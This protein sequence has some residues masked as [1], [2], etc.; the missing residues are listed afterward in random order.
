MA[1]LAEPLALS[2]Y[3]A[4]IGKSSISGVSAGAFMAVQFATA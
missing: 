2:G 1:A 3:D 4:S